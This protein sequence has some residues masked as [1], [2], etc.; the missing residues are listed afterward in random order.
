MTVSVRGIEG[1]HGLVGVELAHSPWLDITQERVDAFAHATDDKQWIHVD[2]ERAA[3]C[4]FGATIAHGFLTLAL[5]P[6]FWRTSVRIEGFT[7]GVN[8]GLDSVRFPAPVPIPSRL[9]ARFRVNEVT[10]VPRG[11]QARL[12][13]TIERDGEVK[14]V[15]MAEMIVRYYLQ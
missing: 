9:R 10:N 12:H 6:H 11:I 15:C 7:M 3:S 1:L 4:A 13:V 8:Y 2:R 5:I 14:P